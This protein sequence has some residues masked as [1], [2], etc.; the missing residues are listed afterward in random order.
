MRIL[1]ANPRGF[2]AGVDRALAIVEE[3]L[4]RFAAP[5]YVRHEIIHNR[6]VVQD[7]SRRGVVFVES[8]QQVPPGS[9][10]IFSAHGV[11]PEVWRE[12]EQRELVVFDATCPLVA[13]VHMEVIR[14]AR[15]NR[16]CVLIGH[17]GHQEVIGTLAHYRNIRA[18][19]IYL[20]ETVADAAALQLRNPHTAA[21][22]T[23]TTLAQDQVAL[24]VEALQNRYPWLRSASR[25]ADI[26]YATQNR[27]DAVKQLALEADLILVLGSANSSNANRLREVAELCGVEAYLLDDAAQL[28]PAWLQGKSAIG[29]TAAASTPAWLVE[30]LI[31]VLRQRGASD[32]RQLDGDDENIVF[33]M[34]AALSQRHRAAHSAAPAL[35]Q[36]QHA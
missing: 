5:V 31:D 22:V 13:K 12:A 18:E 2:C 19:G 28:Q 27:Q 30:E 24:V 9:V 1:L 32:I 7:L 10:V 23:Q 3:A 8:L 15:E 16:E 6:H 29:I 17:A 11:A 14:L 26:C 25:K 36:S 33:P 4:Q 21:Y 20:V 34:P 35:L